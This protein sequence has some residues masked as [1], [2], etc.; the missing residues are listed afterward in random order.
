VFFPSKLLLTQ[1]DLRLM[2]ARRPRAQ[3]PMNA[4]LARPIKVVIVLHHRFELWNAPAWLP[5]RL[6]K[7]FPQI[8]LQQLTRYDGVEDALRDAE[9]VIAWSL[10]PEQFNEAKR[11][12]WIHSPAAAVHQ[13]MFAELVHSDVV[14]TNAREVHGAV[15]A[16]H[17]MA[18]IFAMAK[19]LPEAVRLQQQHKWGQEAMWRGRPRPREVAGATL[20][21]IG[22][23][24][25][26]R[27]VAQRAAALGMRVIA[28]REH[29][30]KGRPQNVAVIFGLAQLDDLLRQSDY[31]VLAAPLTAETRGLMNGERLSRMKPEACLINVSR[32]PLVDDIALATA[33]RE[34][35]I[36]GAALDVFTEEPLSADSPYWDLENVLIT[37]HT[38]AVTE[39]LWD[40]HYELIRENLRRYLAHEP[41]L[42]VVDKRKGY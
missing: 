12:R 25:I 40:R 41:L 2:Q 13:L 14:L 22:L 35:R 4:S 39:K 15:V 16:E 27:E 7:D 36:G 28:V 3:Y 9:V 18:Q 10:R 19:M 33:L 38:A 26:G 11:L 31:V 42:A 5:E 34:K 1:A 8:Q 21:L 32:G 30:E 20:G 24:S 6:Q 29:P 23:G 17:V 37:P